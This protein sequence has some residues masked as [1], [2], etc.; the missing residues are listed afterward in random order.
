MAKRGNGE[1]SIVK[2]ANGRYIARKSKQIGP[3]LVRS[4]KTFDTRKEAQEWLR[5]QDAPAAAGTL[6]E[7]LDTWLALTKPDKANKT[8]KLDKQKIDLHLKP[9]L[10]TV[11]L[12]DLNAETVALMLSQMAGE[13]KSPDERHKV[14]AVLRRAMRAAV[15]MGRLPANPVAGLTL[16]APD[17]DEPRALLP[18]EL[19]AVVGA[20]ESLFQYGH[21]FRLWADAG[22]RPAEMF[23]LQW[24]EI[25]CEKGEVKVSAAIDDVTNE[26][27]KPKTKRSV[28][29]IKLAPSTAAALVVARPPAH[30][31]KQVLPAPQGGVWW[32][33]RFLKSVMKP[34]RAEAGIDWLVPYTFRHTMATLLLRAG[35][36]LKV[37]SERLGHSDVMTT[38]RHYSHVLEGDQDRAAGA[39]ETVLPPVATP[40]P[41]ET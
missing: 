37:V 12:R 32:S 6:G 30:R 2:L 36:P 13:G 5:G 39:M 19:A 26:R 31:G 41:L 25:D 17:P 28:R 34:L 29:A 16:P 9:R 40:L 20:A 18:A 8:H 33:S 38:L 24:H 7:W 21:V 1:G 10:G 4:A 3:K 23:A 22:L 27:K 11:R 14:G 35:V 15:R